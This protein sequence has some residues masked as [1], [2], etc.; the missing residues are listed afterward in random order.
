MEPRR[1][2]NSISTRWT[3]FYVELS[4][5]LRVL[6]A[7]M[8][9]RPSLITSRAARCC[10]QAW[11]PGRTP[12][13]HCLGKEDLDISMTIAPWIGCVESETQSHN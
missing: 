6:I 2:R 1:P 9:R 11:E 8:R 10:F 12:S 13:P 7:L 3:L 5:L 4:S